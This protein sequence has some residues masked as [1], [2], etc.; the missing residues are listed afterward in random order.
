MPKLTVPTKCL[1]T[2]PIHKD[3]RQMMVTIGRV[4][5]Y[6]GASKILPG[7]ACTLL[8]LG[9]ICIY[10]YS[11]NFDNQNERFPFWTGYGERFPNNNNQR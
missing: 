11:A 10:E 8:G 3:T 7:A 9:P 1:G 4:A 6:G 2:V 5:K